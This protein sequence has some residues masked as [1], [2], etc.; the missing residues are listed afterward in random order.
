[1]QRTLSQQQWELSYNWEQATYGE[2]TL[3]YDQSGESQIPSR[4]Y[5]ISSAACHGLARRVVLFVGL[6]P[7]SHERHW[8]LGVLQYW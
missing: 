5:G 3:A 4:E 2:L 7:S 1:M 8:G 6:G